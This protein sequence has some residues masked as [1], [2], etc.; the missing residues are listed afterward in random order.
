M[1]ADR[2]AVATEE[3]VFLRIPIKEAFMWKANK[4]TGAIY[5]GNRIVLLIFF[6]I[7]KPGK[8]RKSR[9][10]PAAFTGFD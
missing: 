4:K 5:P 3:E 1:P 8:M 10:D 7:H 2:K 9:P 6:I